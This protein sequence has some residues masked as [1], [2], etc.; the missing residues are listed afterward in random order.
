MYC[1]FTLAGASFRGANVKTILA[2]QT[3]ESI[4]RFVPEP[5]NRFDANAIKVIDNAT[6]TFIGY[7]P[8]VQTA[9]LHEMLALEPDLTGTVIQPDE[10]YPVIEAVLV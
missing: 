3:D 10:R 2:A 1:T 8:A 7:V 9:E 6:A 5:D 4:V